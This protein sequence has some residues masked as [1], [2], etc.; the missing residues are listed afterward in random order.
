MAPKDLKRK[1]NSLLRVPNT[2]LS[3]LYNITMENFSDDQFQHL[4]ESL[5]Q[6]SSNES[7]ETFLGNLDEIP[8]IAFFNSFCDPSLVPMIN[9]PESL[10]S[11]PPLPLIEEEEYTPPDALSPPS[12]SDNVSSANSTPVSV[13]EINEALETAHWAKYLVESQRSQQEAMKLE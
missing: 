7:Y 11:F 9:D 1:I 2:S 4:L 8:D 12:L 10:L 6:N 3:I 13:P 5:N